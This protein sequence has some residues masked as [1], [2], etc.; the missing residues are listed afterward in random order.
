MLLEGIYGGF[1]MIA[2]RLKVFKVETGPLLRS[3][4]CSQINVV[5]RFS[6]LN[7]L[8]LHEQPRIS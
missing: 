5:M 6:Q 2:N 1:D 7:I 3:Q 4:F 8:F